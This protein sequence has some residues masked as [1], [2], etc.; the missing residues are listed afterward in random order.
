MDNPR[1]YTVGMKQSWV[2]RVAE[3]VVQYHAELGVVPNVAQVSSFCRD[4]PPQVGPVKLVAGRG[5]FEW[6]LRFGVEPI[7]AQSAP[8]PQLPSA[9][10]DTTV[11]S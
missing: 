5:L 9:P 8:Q 4:V 11:Q 3:G 10:L 7:K 1:T 2:K 6:E